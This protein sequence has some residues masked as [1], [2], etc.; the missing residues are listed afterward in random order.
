MFFQAHPKLFEAS[1][2]PF[3]DFGS[4]FY[5]FLRFPKAKEKRPSK[6]RGVLAV[7]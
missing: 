7:N 4:Y 5:D 6:S 2:L 3:Y 1:A